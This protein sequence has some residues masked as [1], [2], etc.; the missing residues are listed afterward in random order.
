MQRPAKPL[1]A[2]RFRFGPPL[3]VMKNKDKIIYEKD[4]VLIGGG[5][6]NLN[7][8]RSFAMRPIKGVRITLISNVYETPY[9]GML[10]GFIENNY[11][12]SEI[13]FDLFKIC[14]HGQFRF[15]KDDVIGILAKKKLLEFNERP[16]MHFDYL[17]INIGICNNKS[18]IINSEKYALTLKPISQINF[19]ELTENLRSKKIG[20]IG[21]G[22][23]GVEISL[24]LEKR[25][26]NIKILLFVG[27]R[28]V[29]PNY[30]KKTQENL[31]N[32]L[33]K[34]NIKIIEKGKVIKIDKNTIYTET[35][36]IEKIDKVILA[37]EGVAPDWLKKSDLNLSIDGFIKTNTKLQ[38]IDYKNIFASGDIISFS[39]RKLTKSGVY[40]VKSSYF[41]EKNIRNIIQNK[42]LIDYK[43]QKHYLSLIGLSNGKALAYKYNIHIISKIA[44]KIKKLIDINFMKKF[45]IYDN[46]QLN[47]S[48]MDC[49]GC[50]AKVDI[51]ALKKS[52]PKNIIN[53]SEDASLISSTKKYVKSVDMINAIITD[54]YLLG[55]V[56]AN[57]ALSDIYS[58]K[59]KPLSASMILQLPKSSEKNY[60]EDIK[61]I[62]S[63]AKYIFDK[64]FCELSGGHT[65][66]GEDI[67][68]VI[69]FSIVGKK[70][71]TDK[72]IID[73]HDRVFLTGKIGVG[74][75][76][77][78]INSNRISSSYLNDVMPQL[79]E[80]NL[81]IGNLFNTINPSDA[82]DITGFGLCN[83]LLNLQN[84]NKNIKGITIYK[85]KVFVF[86][87]VKECIDKNVASSF[88]Q[89]NYNFG[90]NKIIFVKKDPINQIFFDPQTVGG[91]AFIIPKNLS[92]KISILLKNNNI[93]FN[94]IG[95]V[96]NSHNKLKVI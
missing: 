16:P 50:A 8:L 44:F 54:P 60:A 94:E 89:Q 52:L 78:G 77:A 15:I 9:S 35:G 7:V 79:E 67:N 4:L 55:K 6:A 24:A 34:S 76:F 84:R 5:H 58:S 23:A 49:K 38:T 56:S 3:F 93:I 21:S 32:I 91:I 20:I 62:Y 82:T 65:M 66:V 30:S 74:L 27:S 31:K 51:N 73:N 70:Y 12:F 40:A 14:S 37:T 64:N 43:P 90:K 81:K 13:V 86:N 2:V 59:S 1:T 63:G 46:N 45:K 87:G 57:H 95:F 29:L 39:N 26:K 71:S 36:K 61:Q 72:N 75:I 33:L 48:V 83:H 19:K 10:P 88:Y 96:D 22:P 18:K 69:G 17:S 41:L 85:K 68:P 80:G 92:Q 42:P 28:G 53:R 11:S 47:I 25:Y